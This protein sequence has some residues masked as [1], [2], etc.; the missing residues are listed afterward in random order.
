MALL[1]REYAKSDYRWAYGD[2]TIVSLELI[3]VLIYG[4]MTAWICWMI[5]QEQEEYWYFIVVVATGELYGG[6]YFLSLNP[7][8]FL[9]S[10]S[11]FV[12]GKG[13]C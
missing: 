10:I 2:E 4:P 12:G 11:F 13:G 3:T 1:W 7:Y 9:C 8:V 5:V 6:M